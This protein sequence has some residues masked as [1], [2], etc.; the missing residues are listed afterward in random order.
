MSEVQEGSIGVEGS[1]GGR[2]SIYSRV[3]KEKLY[4]T[5]CKLSVALRAHPS[6]SIR[7]RSGF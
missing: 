7:L 4:A 2:V 1:I 5:L 3:N 6:I